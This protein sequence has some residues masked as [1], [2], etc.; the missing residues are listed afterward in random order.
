MA[1]TERNIGIEGLR[2][3]SMLLII[4]GHVLAQG[5]ILR[6]VLPLSSQ[7][8]MAWFLYI[9]ALPAVNCYALIS[10]YVGIDSEFKLKRIAKL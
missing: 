8:Y 10:G 1:L 9:F 7:W 4:I 5:G 3:F 2:I 6:S